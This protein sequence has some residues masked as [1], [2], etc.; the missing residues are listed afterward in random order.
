MTKNGRGGKIKRRRER[1]REI[2]KEKEKEDEENERTN[3]R[4]S[5][6]PE[7]GTRLG[8]GCRPTGVFFVVV[9]VVFLDK[10][11]RGRNTK[12]QKPAPGA[13][14]IFLVVCKTIELLFINGAAISYANHHDHVSFSRRVRISF[15]VR[16]SLYVSVPFLLF[17]SHIPTA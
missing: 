14:A 3:E 7:A 10:P 15:H 11:E 4:T 8:S 1:K 6:T 2:K 5:L 9:V 17:F 12:P 13:V 16:L